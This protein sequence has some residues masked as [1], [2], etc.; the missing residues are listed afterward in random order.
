MRVARLDPGPRRAH[1]EEGVR[2]RD[3]LQEQRVVLPVERERGAVHR[4]R[5]GTEL[6][7]QPPGQRVRRVRRAEQRRER[8]PRVADHRPGV[9]LRQPADLLPHLGVPLRRPAP[10]LRLDDRPP[11]GVRG[12]RHPRAGHQ[13]PGQRPV[14]RPH[15][16]DH[17][18][19]GGGVLRQGHRSE[20]GDL[21]HQPG[22]RRGRVRPAER[23]VHPVLARQP[24]ARR[25]GEPADRVGTGVQGVDLLDPG[26]LQPPLRDHR[27]GTDQALLPRLEEED[28]RAAQPLPQPG[29]RQRDTHPD[30]R[31]DVVPAGVRRRPPLL[32]RHDPVARHRVHVRPVG[33]RPTRPRA[34]QHRD[35]TGPGHRRPVRQ[36]GT[37][38]P[39]GH[40]QPGRPQPSR[41][42]PGGVRLLAR[43]LRVRVQ[44]PP[45]RDQL[46]VQPRRRGVHRRLVDRVPP[47]HRLRRGPRPGHH[48]HGPGP[49][50]PAEHRPPTRPD[51][52][53]VLHQSPTRPDQC[54]AQSTSRF[55]APVK[56]RQHH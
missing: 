8:V 10:E 47:P 38:D 17:G 37:A 34:A 2:A 11:L 45:Q 33:H 28:H 14:R 54:D 19:Q 40:L 5:A 25:H 53:H 56:P 22:R 16:P 26:P 50:H 4:D 30:R 15:V 29:Q 6:A 55:H 12:R 41:D 35:H 39:G 18:L 46:A 7:P 3:P 48:H 52:R 9:R 23:D 51:S 44:R 31:V 27:P 42:L 20:R 21:A 36:G 24:A 49:G 43:G 32:R 13:E 1:A